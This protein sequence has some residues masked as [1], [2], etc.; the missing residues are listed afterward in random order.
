MTLQRTY[1]VMATSCRDD[2]CGY[3]KD[4]LFLLLV[5]VTEACGG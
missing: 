3:A 5:H 1:T 2:G 4:I